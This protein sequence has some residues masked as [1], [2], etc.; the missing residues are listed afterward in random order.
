MFAQLPASAAGLARANGI[1][2]L[3][4]VYFCHCSKFLL[5]QILSGRMLEVFLHRLLTTILPGLQ[6]RNNHSYACADSADRIRW[7]DK[8]LTTITFALYL[9]SY[10]IP[11]PLNSYTL[12]NIMFTCLSLQR[13]RLWQLL[14]CGSAYLMIFF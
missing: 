6:Q 12:Y 7:G 11:L 10:I 5:T 4:Q 1:S 3:D 8:Y 9:S 2:Y 13:C 14:Q